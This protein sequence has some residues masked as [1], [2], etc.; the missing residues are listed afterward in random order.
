MKEEDDE[1]PVVEEIPVYLSQMLAEK[2]FIYQYPL[3]HSEKGYD[4]TRVIA[5][6]VKPQHQ[7]VRLEIGLDARNPNF[8]AGKA[9]QIALNTDGLPG[10]KDEKKPEEKLFKSDVM[11]KLVLTSTRSV[12]AAS[13]YALGVLLDKELHVTPV[14]GILALRPSFGYL[15]K[16]DRR[17]KEDAKERGEEMSGEEDGP[18]E[19][20]E[21]K[22]ITVKFARRENDKL[23]QARE[24][25]YGFLSKRIA[26]ESWYH[27]DY[28]HSKTDRAEME[29]SKLYCP[30]THEQLTELSLSPAEYLAALLP[31]GAEEEEAAAAPGARPSSLKDLRRLPLVDQVKAVLREAK[32][33][34][35]DAL[36]SLLPAPADPKAVL[37]AV[38]QAGVLVRGN[39][40]VRSDVLHPK[41]SA[42]DLHGVP[43][44]IM[45]RARDHILHQL[46]QHQFVDRRQVA[47]EVRLPFEEVKELLSQVARLRPGRGW[48]LL[49]PL[50]D[51]FLSRHPEVAERQR[52]W[53]EA[54]RGQADGGLREGPPRPPGRPRRQSN[55]DSSVGSSDGEAAAGGRRRRKSTQRDSISSD[56]GGGGDGSRAQRR[57]PAKDRP[58]VK[59][60]PPET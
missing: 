11:D 56:E 35:F 30:A 37:R 60:E 50:D 29:R 23:K 14:R 32:V 47:A 31:R 33:L 1:D 53:W 2:L 43:A 4:E 18:E 38:Q 21:M 46:D 10:R 6:C 20:E 26:E 40:V 55:R 58:V 5:S 57:R 41:D 22:Q 52:L 15:D 54:K 39:W 17:A 9:E 48:E 49:L 45:C 25:S 34:R 16:S 42:S 3:K 19:E 7:E 28:H 13:N 12:P 27:T 24:R 36:T 59:P 44:E 51:D 8:D